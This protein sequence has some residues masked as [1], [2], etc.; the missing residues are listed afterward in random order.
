MTAKSDAKAAV[1]ALR[2]LARRLKRRRGC[3]AQL[4]VGRPASKETIASYT[5]VLNPQVLEFAAAADGIRFTWWK[6]R[7][8]AGRLHVPTLSEFAESTE[9]HGLEPMDALV[10]R[11]NHSAESEFVVM[12]G[13]G[14]ELLVFDG[15]YCQQA[16]VSTLAEVVL[17]GCESEFRPGWEASLNANGVDAD[18]DWEE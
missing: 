1:H 6:G 4:V 16:T 15:D 9:T 18:E 5:D 11:F 10:Q 17:H 13:D 12:V 7:T 8:E 2:A 14:D 3:R